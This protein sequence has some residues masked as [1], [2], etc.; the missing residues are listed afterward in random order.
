MLTILSLYFLAA[1]SRISFMTEEIKKLS[2]KLVELDKKT[3]QLD[4]LLKDVRVEIHNVL[5]DLMELKT[6]SVGKKN[7]SLL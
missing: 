2:Q 1:G 5:W 6:N 3:E 7:K 4:E